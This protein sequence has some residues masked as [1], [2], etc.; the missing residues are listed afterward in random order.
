MLI[1]MVFGLAFY[2][3]F[4]ATI[5]KQDQAEVYEVAGQGFLNTRDRMGII[6]PMHGHNRTLNLGGEFEQAAIQR[7]FCTSAKTG[8]NLLEK[9][10]GA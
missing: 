10:M 2:P 3:G 7:I 9:T 4:V 1:K 8:K 6:I 5:F